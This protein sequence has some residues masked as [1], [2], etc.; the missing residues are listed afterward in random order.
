MDCIYLTIEKIK[1]VSIKFYRIAQDNIFELICS[2]TGS[3]SRY[4]YAFPIFVWKNG[5][6][7]DLIVDLQNHK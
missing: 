3:R 1:S 7:I 4:F 5:K 2:A 6:F